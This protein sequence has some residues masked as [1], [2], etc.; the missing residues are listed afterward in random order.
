M[1]GEALYRGEEEETKSK[2]LTRKCC[3][4]FSPKMSCNLVIFLNECECRNLIEISKKSHQ[5]A[6]FVLHLVLFEEY[7][8]FINKETAEVARII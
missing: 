7:K 6:I 5:S 1:Q 2:K 4:M 3:E 8:I